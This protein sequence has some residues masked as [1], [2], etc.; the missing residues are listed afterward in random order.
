MIKAITFD[1]WDTVFIDDSDEPKRKAAGK[2][3]KAIERRQLVKQF[4]DK[5]QQ[6]P[7]EIVNAAYDAQDAAFRKAWHDLQITWSV[8]ERLEIV[9]KGIGATLPEDELAEL[10]RL[11]E[12]ME[13]EFRPDFVPGVHEAI[14][15]LSEKYKLG[16]IS[17][18][19]F[20]PGRSLR[21]LL[22]D[23]GLL[24]YFSTFVFSDEVGCSKP[25]VCVFNAAKKGLGVEFNEIVHIGDREH[26]DI[27]GPEKM[28]MKSILCLAALDRGSNRNRADAYFENYSEL[29]N[30][31]KNLKD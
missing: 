30:L 11:H 8:K 14:K 9:L 3:T 7:Q 27:L 24:Q 6:V 29:P 12:E 23:E 4:V 1:L 31:I 13:L 28:G 17:D 21:K 16:V 18:A 19:I 20:S 5:H 25:H 15:T 2:P 22:E 26:N 10:V